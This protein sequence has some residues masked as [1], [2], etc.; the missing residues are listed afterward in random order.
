MMRK[1]MNGI[2]TILGRTNCSSS[3][4]QLRSSPSVR[5]LLTGK[6]HLSPFGPR[7]HFGDFS[8]SNSK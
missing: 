5:K 8:D 4:S 1:N 6:R 7:S 2:P 3:S